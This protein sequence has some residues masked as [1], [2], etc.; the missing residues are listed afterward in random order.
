MNHYSVDY[1]YALQWRH[2]GHDS[3]SN[4]QPHDC[5][6]N[7][8][9]DA[10][11]SK[12]ESSASLAYVRGIHRGPVNSLRKWPVMWKMFLFD[13]VIMASCVRVHIVF[14]VLCVADTYAFV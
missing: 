10:D 4:H 9:S 7:L 14:F 3:V 2:N 6:L 8:Y 11:Q 1:M 12:H 5:L 13:D